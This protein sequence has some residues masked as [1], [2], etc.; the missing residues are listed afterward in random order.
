MSGDFSTVLIKDST[1]A[2]ITDKLTY[3]VQSG[4]SSNTFQKF[5]AISNGNTSLTF[6]INVP[7]ENV[8][9]NRE[10]FIKTKIVFTL[11][12]TDYVPGDNATPGIGVVT[13]LQS[14]P[15]NHLVTTATAQIN[16]TSVSTNLQDILPMLLQMAIQEELSKYNG[17]TPTL[18]D[19]VFQSPSDILSTVTGVPS[20]C[21]PMNEISFSGHNKFYQP[22]GAF[23][24]T[25]VG[26]SRTN[27]AGTV[28]ET[29]EVDADTDVFKF[30]YEVEVT[31]P[32]IGLSPFIYGSPKYN[33]QGLVGVNSIN[34][35]LN[36]DST[37]KRFLTTYADI[38]KITGITMGRVLGIGTDNS[39]AFRDPA[40]LMNFMTPQS[41]DIILSR[42]VV[43]YIDLPRYIASVTN[44]S[45]IG[46]GTKVRLTSQNIQLNQIPD[47]FVIAVRKPM[48][49]QT[50][51]DFEFSLAIKSI[52]I[53]FSNTSGLLSSASPE[54]LYRM[55]VDNG[56][57]QSWSQFRGQVNKAVGLTTSLTGVSDMPTNGAV[58]VLSPPYDMSLPDYLT[59]GSIGN[60]N[61]QF[62]IDVFNQTA[63]DITPELVVMTV[64]SGIF[65]TIAGSSNI[66]TGILTKQMVMDAKDMGSVNPVMSV[67]HK[68]M[69]GGGAGIFDQ[70]LSAVKENPAVREYAKKALKSLAGNGISS[71]G[72]ISHLV[73]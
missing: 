7:S 51:F 9:V 46:A 25:Q 72:R 70:A 57:M 8:I 63:D 11:T 55:S 42:N 53:N 12:G 39:A 5:N 62:E 4:A 16:N 14:F 21:N 71:G 23:Q 2:G 26:Y 13:A 40:I 52:S 43:P 48:S 28:E 64:N 22:R 18:V 41:K 67:E 54:D 3:A 59:S 37:M 34:I 61:F 58:L 15:F 33:N 73:R 69:I 1:I 47:L 56:S 65:T 38:S 36:I 60:Y 50:I 66:Y 31:E 10:V 45:A 24:I 19:S 20:L 27:L 17:M 32:L 49:T 68:R 6:N 44:P 29:L 35:V 30:C